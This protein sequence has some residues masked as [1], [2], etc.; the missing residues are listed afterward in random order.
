MLDTLPPLYKK[1]TYVGKS[2][3][4]PTPKKNNPGSAPVYT[5]LCGINIYFSYK[6]DL[7]AT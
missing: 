6:H 5:C 1:Q 3:D 2:L 4:R 7:F